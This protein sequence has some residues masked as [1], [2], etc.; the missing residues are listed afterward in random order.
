MA[1]RGYTY[2][3]PEVARSPVSVEDLKTLL[4]TAAFGD[5]DRQY[6]RKAGEVLKDQVEEILDLWYGFVGSLPHLLHYFTGPD[7]QPI[8]EYLN[9]VRQ[10]FGQWIL[11]TCEREYDQQ[12]LDYQHEIA[13]RHHRAKKN[14]TDGVQAPD[15]IPLRYVLALAAPIILTIKPFLQKKGHSPEEVEKMHAAWTKAIIVQMALWSLPYA[16]EGDW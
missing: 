14:R 3:T 7:G 2:G 16:R 4:A 8:A 9:A 13:L 11:D 1:I 10:R 12:W 6:L 15:H 5:E